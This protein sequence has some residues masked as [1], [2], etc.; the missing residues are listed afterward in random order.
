VRRTPGEAK[1]V[2]H[3]S[4]LVEV[5]SSGIDM[6]TGTYTILAQTVSE[7]LGVPLEQVMVSLG[8]TA[9]PRAP[10]AGGSQLANLLTGVVH[11]TALGARDELLALAV[12]D[13]KSPF[14]LAKPA[15]LSWKD[16]AVHLARRPGNGTS[17]AELL[18]ATGRE[19]LEIKR[20]TFKPGATEKDRDAANRSFAQMLLPTDGGVSAHSWSAI[21]VEVRVDEDFGTIRV[22]RMVGAFDCG[23]IYNPK[24]AESQWMGGMI[25]GMGQ[26][27]LE[28]GHTD[29]R[30]GRI[31]NANL[32][33]YMVAV[34]ADVPD[35]T[36]ISVG[37]ADLQASAM[38][39]KAVGE[40]GI[41]GVAAAIGNAVFHATGKRIRDLPITLEKLA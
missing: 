30:D 15:D 11:K 17:I 22:K 12:A 7:V 26:A 29:P 9:L 40:V 8:D 13:P 23:R 28:A 35:I 25:M 31:T 24:L 21:F 41:V 2:L 18:K 19:R 4:G 20:D 6:G 37:V 34:N 10:V 1:I 32:A 14:Y 38:G 27:L 3:A 5:H 16:G 33:D 39:G 36:T